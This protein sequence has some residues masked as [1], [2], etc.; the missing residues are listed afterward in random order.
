VLS[1]YPEDLDDDTKDN[2]T[3]ELEINII[4][5]RLSREL[6]RNLKVVGKTQLLDDKLTLIIK[7]LSNN[8]D[9]KKFDKYRWHNN[10]LYRQEKGNWRLV[11]PKYLSNNLIKE[12]HELYGHPGIKKTALLFKEYFTCNQANALI[13]KLIKSCPT[14]QK[15]KDYSRSIVGE[16]RPIIPEA[17][18]D[19]I[20]MDYYGPLP[21]STAG[22]KY[23]LVVV[24]NFT[25]YVKLYSLKRATT[26]STINRL[27]QYISEYGKPNAV[28]TDNGTQFTTNKWIQGLK[29]LNIQPRFTAI[30]NPCTNLAERVNRQLGNLFRVFVKER[31]TKWAQYLKVIEVCLNE[32]V[33]ETIQTTPYAAQFGKPPKREWKQYV[34]LDIVKEEPIA[35]HQDIFLRIK[36]K[37]EKEARKLNQKNKI[38]KFELGDLVLVKAY[39]MSDALNKIVS[40]FCELYEGPYRIKKILSASTYVLEYTDQPNK[41][42]GTFNV[43]QMKQYYGD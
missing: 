7:E 10:K 39:Q 35:K 5:L 12:L 16:T 15:C 23:L 8:S 28:L 6:K 14:C 32:T 18:G 20:S 25:K 43:R 19:L 22:V 4:H 33:H 21:T 38:T 9:N 37:R 1:R 40:K 42:R 30:R 29:E 26:V 17:K 31:H 2:P 36:T 11:I 24:D 27:K 41:I 3:D 13:K 34:D